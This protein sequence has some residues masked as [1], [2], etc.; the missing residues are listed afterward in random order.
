[1]GSSLKPPKLLAKCWCFCLAS[2]LLI[3]SVPSHLLAVVPFLTLRCLPPALPA[4]SAVLDRVFCDGHPHFFVVLASTRGTEEC[5]EK[6]I[7]GTW[8]VHT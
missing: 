7:A 2:F 5:A 3:F 6:L 8:A 4:S 1:M